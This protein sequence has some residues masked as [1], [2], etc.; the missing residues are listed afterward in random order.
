MSDVSF[1]DLIIPYTSVPTRTSAD[2]SRYFAAL[3]SFSRFEKKRN[4]WV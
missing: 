2:T 3:K 1:A 4:I